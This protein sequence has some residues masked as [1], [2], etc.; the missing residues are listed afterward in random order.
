MRLHDLQQW[1]PHQLSN[2][3]CC[4]SS[5]QPGRNRPALR[6]TLLYSKN[7]NMAVLVKALL[8]ELLAVSWYARVLISRCRAWARAGVPTSSSG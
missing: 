2:Y 8:D 7:R 6:L 5:L 3:L 1:V 4:S